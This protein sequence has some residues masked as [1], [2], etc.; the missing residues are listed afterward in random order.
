MIF[1]Y[2]FSVML[3]SVDR[4]GV[5]FYAQLFRHAHDAYEAFMS[6]LQ[7]DLAAVFSA[8][9]LHIPIV[10]AEADYHLPLPHGEPVQVRVAVAK[11][12]NTSFTLEC[13]FINSQGQ[14]AAR[15]ATVHVCI[16]P[17]SRQPQPLPQSLRDKLNA[18]LQPYS[19]SS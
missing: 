12:G 2:D 18:N 19:G 5:L 7:E 16:N 10:H 15:V 9:D 14:S 3:S 11:V 1:S 13:E 4:A 8:G 17:H 6:Q